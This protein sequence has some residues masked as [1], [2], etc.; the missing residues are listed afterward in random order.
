MGGS[1]SGTG[2]LT[3]EW[4]ALAAGRGSLARGRARDPRGEPGIELSCAQVTRT[5]R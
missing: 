3:E 2:A 5:F 1:D 4:G